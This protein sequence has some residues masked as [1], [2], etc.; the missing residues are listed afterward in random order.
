MTSRSA[1]FLAH[2]RPTIIATLLLV[3]LA[4]TPAA[5]AASSGARE[6]V[7]TASAG[8]QGR[9]I[10]NPRPRL[11]LQPARWPAG[12]SAGAVRFGAGYGHPGGD[13]RVREVQRRLTQL[14]YRPGPVDGLFGPRTRAATKW[15]Q[16]KHGLEHTGG[17]NQTTLAV[18]RSRSDH[19]PLPATHEAKS[20]R[21]IENPG[22][23]PA[24]SRGDEPARSR[25]GQPATGRAG[26]S[27]RHPGGRPATGGKAKA[28]DGKGRADEPRSG[29]RAGTGSEEPT[30]PAGAGM[31]SD[32]GHDRVALIV[33]LLL[34]LLALGAGVVV[35]LYGLDLFRKQP[36]TR[37]PVPPARPALPRG[38]LEVAP[39]AVRPRPSSGMPEATTA[40]ARPRPAP[41]TT[42]VLGYVVVNHIHPETNGTTL[43][44]LEAL[45]V[46]R[47]WSLTKVVHDRDPSTGRMA[48]RQGLIYALKDIRAGDAAGI[49]VARLRDFTRLRDLAVLMQWVADAD[50]FVAAADRE[51]DTSTRAGRA[52]A[53]AIVELGRWERAA[54]AERTRRDLTNGRF[55]PPVGI[56]Q[57]IGPYLGTMR[58][59]GISLRA[60]SDALNLGNVPAPEGSTRWRPATVQAVA[61]ER[62]R[63]N[64]H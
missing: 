13:R 24:K 44:S 8:W 18:L 23:R 3:V 15:F 47:G 1:A 22:G 61:G 14:G 16:Y 32:G 53:T 62:P 38:A 52:T 25:G 41:T 59:R 5:E 54:I 4:M 51:L 9:A 6:P 48:D 31:P 26:E 58:D 36:E 60:I 64:G 11:R 35:G 49:V 28:K 2:L 19:E 56:N 43:E 12:W 29:V 21:T 46:R 39:P 33:A 37:K 55:T 20:P 27:A 57:E 17:V 45:C 7:A 42:P 10:E 63:N 30:S 40:V 34:L 50:G